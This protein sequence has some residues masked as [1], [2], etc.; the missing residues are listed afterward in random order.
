MKPYLAFGGMNV[1]VHLGWS[2]FEKQTADR[3]APFHQG[4]VIAFEQRVVERAVFDRA[5]VDEQVLVLARG[6][7][8]AWRAH[9]AP[10]AKHRGSSLGGRV[11]RHFFQLVRLGNVRHKI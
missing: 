6:S 10:D 3:I 11:S 9:E 7:R 2:Q 8:N 1:D 4:S 5:A